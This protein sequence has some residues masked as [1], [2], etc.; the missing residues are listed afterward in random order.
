MTR[1]TWETRLGEDQTE[2]RS[3][4]ISDLGMQVVLFMQNNDSVTCISS[5]VVSKRALILTI[6]HKKLVLKIYL[7]TLMVS[8]DLQTLNCVVDSSILNILNIFF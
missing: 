8:L 7:E 6:G 2:V 4:S 5:K 3:L 1:E